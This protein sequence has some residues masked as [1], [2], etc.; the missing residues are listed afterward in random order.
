VLRGHERDRCGARFGLVGA[1]RV[2]VGRGYPSFLAAEV[3]AAS[4][5]A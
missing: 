1:A 4:A 2:A 5:G 3:A